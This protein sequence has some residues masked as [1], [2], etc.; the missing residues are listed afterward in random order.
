MAPVARSGSS[1]TRTRFEAGKIRYKS[2]VSTAE[3]I[4]PQRSIFWR[5]ETSISEQKKATQVR[6]GSQA[7]V[8]QNA[9]AAKRTPR[10]ILCSTRSKNPSLTGGSTAARRP[11]AISELFALSDHQRA[12]P[13]VRDG[14]KPVQ[15]RILYT[16][17]QQGLGANAKHRKCAKVV[18]A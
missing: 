6:L 2:R 3:D 11:R 13:D 16:M 5:G 14:L 15:R 10:T 1:R 7:S 9:A 17:N 12:L 4:Y 18:G 8:I